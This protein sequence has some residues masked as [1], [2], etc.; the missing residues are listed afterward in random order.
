MEADYE[1]VGALTVAG[2]NSYLPLSALEYRLG[3]IASS[4]SQLEDLVSL[5]RLF[6]A[7]TLLSGIRGSGP[8]AEAVDVRCPVDDCRMRVPNGRSLML[9]TCPRCAYRFYVT[10]RT[11]E[12]DRRGSKARQLASVFRRI[13]G[14]A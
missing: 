10:T 3:E 6:D 7:A 4:R 12:V 5:D 2:K 11:T 1:S 9:V 8:S 14:R 13:Y